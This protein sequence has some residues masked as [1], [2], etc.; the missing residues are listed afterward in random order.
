MLCSSII[1]NGYLYVTMY[2]NYGNGS[3]LGVEV[4]RTADGDN[5]EKVITNGFGLGKEQGYTGGLTMYKEAV[6]FMLNNLSSFS[7][8]TASTGFRLWKSLDGKTWEQ[9][10]EPGF[11]NPNNESVNALVSRGVLYLATH[12]IKEVNQVWRYGP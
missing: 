8:D 11:G 10:G 7:R 2:G 5:W 4:I 9:V 12:N 1:H 6:Y 3:K